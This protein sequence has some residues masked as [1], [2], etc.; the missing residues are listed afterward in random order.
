MR[1]IFLALFLLVFSNQS[2]AC[3]LALGYEPFRT[4]PTYLSGKQPE[5]PVASVTS[6]QRGFDDG[7]GGSCS[8]AGIITIK[9]DG[10]NSI[11]TTGYK[12]RVKNDDV[13]ANIFPSEPVKI[14]SYRAKDREL[15]FA[16]Y[17]LGS[18]QN[19]TIDFVVQIVA[20]SH[21]GVESEPFDLLV[22]ELGK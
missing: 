8:D 15:S 17:D 3:S 4:S 16:W 2:L 19:Q 7:N 14:S 18:T 11:G 20:V 1:Y 6:I 5:A 21:S 9:V 13:F 22:S 10:A 12:F